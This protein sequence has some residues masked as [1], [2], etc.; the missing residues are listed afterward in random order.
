[1]TPDPPRQ[2]FLFS[3][4]M[5]DAPDREK[6][7]FPAQKE[8][9][10]AKAIADALAQ[11]GAAGEDLGFSQA[12]AGGDLLFIEACQRR[13]VRVPVLL[14]FPEPEFIKRS[15]IASANGDQWRDRYYA[16]RDKLKD[17]IRIM[18][19]Q[20]GPTPSGVDAYERCNLW[21]LDSALAWG[22]DKVRF[23]A[24]W[25]GSGG[26]GPG[27]TAHMYNEVK[28]RAGQ[29]MWLDTRKLW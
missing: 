9:I 11:L 20:L 14:P 29:A 5:V 1:M 13:G 22:A 3:G 24:L 28:S 16:A 12:A 19:D 7:R 27:G 23:I 2:V 21:L 8:P 26:D 4:H 15:I 18:P 25:N 17:P 6:P 10:A